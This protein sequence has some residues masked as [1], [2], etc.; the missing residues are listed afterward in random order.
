MWERFR[1]REK[2]YMILPAIELPK[3]VLRP[4]SSLLVPLQVKSKMFENGKK[5]I[6]HD[7][8]H[9]A[10]LLYSYSEGLLSVWGFGSKYFVV[11]MSHELAVK[12]HFTAS[13]KIAGSK[14]KLDCGDEQIIV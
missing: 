5:N 9:R 6:E 14:N 3:V 7:L 2:K 10:Q 11:E 1:E 4:L 8:S 13:W 12:F